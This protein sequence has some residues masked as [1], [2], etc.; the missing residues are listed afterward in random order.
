MPLRFE[1]LFKCTLNTVKHTSFSQGLARTVNISFFAVVTFLDPGA[2]D[3]RVHNRR[4]CAAQFGRFCD[5]GPHL[6]RWKHCS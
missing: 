1:V 4:V 6:A 5:H 3:T 2:A